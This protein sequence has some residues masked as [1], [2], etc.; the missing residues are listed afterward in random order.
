MP[1][2]YKPKLL[3]ETAARTRPDLIEI[4]ESIAPLVHDSWSANKLK[5]GWKYDPVQSQELKHNPYLL[6]YEDLAEDVKDLDRNTIW[7]TFAAL[8]D[9][10]YTIEKK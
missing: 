5:N 3:D 4:V 6:P 7:T 9:L 2:N 10:G 1:A 8:I